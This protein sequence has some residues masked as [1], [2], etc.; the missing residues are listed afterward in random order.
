MRGSSVE[1]LRDRRVLPQPAPLDP[2]AESLQ[3]LPELV[4]ELLD[5]RRFLEPVRATGLPR[6][7]GIE[8]RPDRHGTTGGDGTEVVMEGEGVITREWL[9]RFVVTAVVPVESLSVVILSFVAEFTSGFAA[10]GALLEQR[11]GDDAA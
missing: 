8:D 2:L 6:L 10:A 5:V 4:H 11:L 1:R 7:C 9:A 3:P